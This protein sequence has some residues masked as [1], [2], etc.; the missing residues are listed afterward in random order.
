LQIVISFSA[1]AKARRVCRAKR[2]Y[3]LLGME[4]GI[5]DQCFTVVHPG[6]Y[7]EVAELSSTLVGKIGAA[8]TIGKLFPNRRRRIADFIDDLL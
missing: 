4:S 8:S 6:N 5:L 7:G 2:K 3:S 1:R